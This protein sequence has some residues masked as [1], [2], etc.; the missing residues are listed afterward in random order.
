MKKLLF[1]AG[2][3][4]ALV[5]GCTMNVSSH[6]GTSGGANKSSGRTQVSLTGTE[7]AI[8]TGFYVLNGQKTLISNSVPWSVDSEG[9][10][11]LEIHKANSK[12]TVF[13]KLRYSEPNGTKSSIDH[14]LRPGVRW[15]KV[16][17]NRG[18]ETTTCCR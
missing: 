2:T 4:A 9:I 5:T 6:S 13:A 17:I 7:H 14:N 8:V 15:M 16:R 1:L 11:Q 3:V 18:L 10:S 12:D